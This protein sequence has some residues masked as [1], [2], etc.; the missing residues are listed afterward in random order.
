MRQGLARQG[1]GFRHVAGVVAWGAR[2]GTK[3]C[4]LG[5]LRALREASKASKQLALVLEDDVRL[6]EE[7]M[8]QI[9]GLNQ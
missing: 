7:P 3:G 5:H 4:G 9:Y 2:A 1:L 8:G 6:E